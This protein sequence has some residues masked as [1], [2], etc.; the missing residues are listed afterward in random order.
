MFG[1]SSLGMWQGKAM[2]CH[3]IWC[4]HNV[5][6][7]GSG[8]PSGTLISDEL[9]RTRTTLLKCSESL[10]RGGEGDASVALGGG[11]GSARQGWGV[12]LGY[13]AIRDVLARMLGMYRKMC[14]RLFRSTSVASCSWEPR[15]QANTWQSGVSEVHRPRL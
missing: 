6:M 13:F 12:L 11:R 15:H 5:W 14:A 3:G 10:G 8:T 2:P 4:D 7:C 1:T 9:T